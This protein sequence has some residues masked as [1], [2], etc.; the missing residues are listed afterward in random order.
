MK[1]SREQVIANRETHRRGCGQAV[2]RERF[3]GSASRSLEGGRPDARGF[4]VT[5]S[6]RTISRRRMQP[7]HGPRLGKVGCACPY[8]S[9]GCR[10]AEIVKQYLTDSIAMTRKVP[11]RGA[12]CP[13]PDVKDLRYDEPSGSL[14]SL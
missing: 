13:M 7:H 9:R 14:G 4:T 2:P 11:A 8:V 5:S 1:V 3:D 12:R 6:R 10:R